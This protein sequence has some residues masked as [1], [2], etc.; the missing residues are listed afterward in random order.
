MI[1]I[2]KYYSI[3]TNILEDIIVSIMNEQLGVKQEEYWIIVNLQEL[4]KIF[5]YVKFYIKFIILIIM[6]SNFHLF[7]HNFAHSI[8]ELKH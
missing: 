6:Y 7:I 2:K 8:Q 5:A 1:K 4:M 3:M